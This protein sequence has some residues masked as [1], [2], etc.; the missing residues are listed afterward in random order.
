VG[1]VGI[2][3]TAVS[4]TPLSPAT[5]LQ[6]ARAWTPFPGTGLGVDVGSACSG[7]GIVVC[8]PENA[9]AFFAPT[10]Y[11]GLSVATSFGLSGGGDLAVM[12]GSATLDTQT[13]PVP[14]PGVLLLLGTGLAAVVTRRRRREQAR[15]DRAG[16]A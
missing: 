10:T 8:P 13:P 12:T 11:D 5:T 2:D 16:R 7:S 9:S 14:E 1:L 6:V 4:L 3:G 15:R